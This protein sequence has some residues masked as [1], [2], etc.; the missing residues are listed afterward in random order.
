MVLTDHTT[1]LAESVVCDPVLL[2]MYM[3]LCA[4]VVCMR[5]VRLSCLRQHGWTTFSSMGALLFHQL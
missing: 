3:A 2:D 1:K 5:V 4:L